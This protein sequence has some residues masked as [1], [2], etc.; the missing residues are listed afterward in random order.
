MAFTEDDLYKWAYDGAP[1]RILR[2]LAKAWFHAEHIPQ[3][4]GQYR[5]AV[6][7]PAI[8]EALKLTQNAALSS[9]ERC[10]TE[11]SVANPMSTHPAQEPMISPVAE[12]Q[13]TPS[14]ARYRTELG[15]PTMK[16]SELAEEVDIHCPFWLD[17]NP[18]ERADAVLQFAGAAQLVF[19]AVT[20]GR[21]AAA[22]LM[23]RYDRQQPHDYLDMAFALEAAFTEAI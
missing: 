6:L 13:A 16:R 20:E 22:M 23:H 4:I 21:L 11:S 10:G 2:A 19:T 5:E 12:P 9:G 8:E 15:G 1:S 14:P 18:L 17:L 3:N 7:R